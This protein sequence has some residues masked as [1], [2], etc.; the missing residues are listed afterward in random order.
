[1]KY[2]FCLIFTLCLISI[3]TCSNDD[4]TDVAPDMKCDESV[5]I[6]PEG[7]YSSEPIEHT[8]NGITIEE[9]CLNATIGGSGCDGSTWVIE[10]IDSGD[11]AE[12]FPPRRS[13]KFRFI[14]DE[15][16]D[17]VVETDVSFDITELR[18]EDGN[19]ILL[20]VQGFDQ[21]LSY[22]Y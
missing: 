21:R 22:K 13:L 9:D 8:V 12:S 15:E 2:P 17:A 6:I 4:V 5:Q 1:M 7:F 10:L 20:K 19:E 3:F 14:N 11:I 16:C 18:L